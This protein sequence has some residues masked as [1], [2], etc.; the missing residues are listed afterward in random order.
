MAHSTLT[1]SD[2]QY[3]RGFRQLFPEPVLRRAVACR[4]QPT[5][6]RQ[7]PLYLL[8]G[9]L[10][11]WFFKPQANLPFLLRW[12]LPARTP[13][14]SAV[15]LYR[16]RA[17]LGW[18]PLCWLRRHVLRPLACP[19]RDGYAFYHGRRVVAL[20]GTTFTVADTPANAR[21]FGRAR[22]QHRASGYPLA[23]VVA[24]CEV[25]THAL[26]D[27]CVRGYNRSEVALARRLW[28]RVP[29]DAVLLAD[30]NFHSYELWYDRQ[31]GGYDLLLR[32]QQG[33]KFPVI[34]VL[35]D[36]SYL[37][38]VRPGRRRG[39]LPPPR[40][41]PALPVRVLLYQWRDRRGR[42]QQA[43][44]LTSLLDAERYPAA[45]LL[46]LYHRRWEQ[47]IDQAGC[48]SSGNLYLG[49]VAA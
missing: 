19:D 8:L 15:A 46:E 13:T 41:R 26:L 43:R 2:Y 14:P 28:R 27:W 7:L 36:G 6:D 18:A 45:E 48:R 47:E 21:T 40:V 44:L 34:A 11:T 12:L 38:R 20:D 37:S 49:G 31:H 30:R 10:L 33:P 29:A 4:H 32:V 17:R 22:N 39:R 23:R 42:L 3:L 5:R 1:I 25:G 9:V 16:A 24:L 35:A